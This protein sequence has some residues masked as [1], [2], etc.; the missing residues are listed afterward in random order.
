MPCVRTDVRP[1]V[2]PIVYER[3]Q[4]GLGEFLTELRPAVALFLRFGGIDYAEDDA[5]G[6]KLD[7][8]I[9]WVQGVIARHE[10]TLIQLTVGDKGS[11]LYAAF[12]APVA[13][14]DDARRAVM[15]AL[16]LRT[17][18]IELNFAGSAQIGIAQ[19]AMRAGTYGGSTRHT[20]GVLGDDVNLAA[21]LM[22][23]AAA[24]EILVSGRVH[25]ALATGFTFEPR[26]PL[27]FKGKAE[28]VPVFAATGLQKRHAVRLQEPVYALPMV[29]RQEELRLIEE[30]IA[31][32]LS[33]KGQVIGITAEAGMGKSRLAAEAIRL[34]QRRGLTGFGGACQSDGVNTSY[35]VWGPVF[36]GLFGV[37]ADA[38]SR[39]Q[40]RILEGEIAD[41]GA[42]PCRRHATLACGAGH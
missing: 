25:K 19:G 36:R 12:G 6:D 28:P 27:R 39:R 9:R 15:T 35:L 23:Q 24:N 13:H 22:N 14:E 17:P 26:P 18:P 10:G 33:G 40:I 7:A 37:D 5:A 21:R 11:Y 1:W 41:S 4:A 8:Y 34:A 31:L 29:G 3:L 20:Y 16:T 2:L 42:R 30:K 38:P 32:A